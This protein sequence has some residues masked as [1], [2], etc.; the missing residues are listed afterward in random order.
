MVSH[1]LIARRNSASNRSVCVILSSQTYWRPPKHSA[2]V[3]NHFQ[4]D[5][6]RPNH[7][8]ENRNVI[9]S[10]FYEIRCVQNAL[11]R[12]WNVIRSCYCHST[13]TH[14]DCESLNGVNLETR[15]GGNRYDAIRFLVNHFGVIHSVPSH[16][17]AMH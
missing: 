7:C 15:T 5:S 10:H 8:D 11:N 9:V 17:V 2:I 3:E 12:S 1:S 16:F 4:T 13:E 14:F 6:M